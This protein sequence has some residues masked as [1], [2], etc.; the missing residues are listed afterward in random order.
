MR[1]RPSYHLACSRIALPAMLAAAALAAAP[2]AGAQE[3]D[4]HDQGGGRL[5]RVVFPV[6]CSPEARRRFEH[7]MAALHSFWWKR[8]SAPSATF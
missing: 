2:A 3:H 7:A 8:V 5:G 1:S 6:S 4:H